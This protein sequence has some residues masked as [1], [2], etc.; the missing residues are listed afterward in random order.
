M[1]A[2]RR[3]R[4]LAPARDNEKLEEG[5]GEER[6]TRLPGERGPP[7]LP[8]LLIGCSADPSRRARR[9]SN[10]Q[11]PPIS[12]HRFRHTAEEDARARLPVLVVA[13]GIAAATPRPALSRAASSEGSPH[14]VPKAKVKRRVVIPK[15]SL[16]RAVLLF[17]AQ[18]LLAEA[19]E[20]WRRLRTRTL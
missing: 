19:E 18:R 6:A 15:A 13:V 10:R 4:A 5:E 17:S 12:R 20:G 16:Q 1:V 3:R 9:R 2:G 11:V 14:F 8:L 7:Q